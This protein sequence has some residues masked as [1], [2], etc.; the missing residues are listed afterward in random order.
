MHAGANRTFD[1]ILLFSKSLNNLLINKF[2]FLKLETLNE[3]FNW[4]D[5]NE[6]DLPKT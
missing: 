2:R 5:I 4:V 1:F 3:D 6:A